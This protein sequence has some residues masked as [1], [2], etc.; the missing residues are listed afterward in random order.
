MQDNLLERSFAHIVVEWS[1]G[2]MNSAH[3]GLANDPA[4]VRRRRLGGDAQPCGIAHKVVSRSD[5][6]EL[7]E[8]S[9]PAEY[10]TM[11]ATA[12]DG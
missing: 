7:F 4:P 2:D 12:T 10:A 6:C 11:T 8:I 5:E 3:A 9:S 1:P